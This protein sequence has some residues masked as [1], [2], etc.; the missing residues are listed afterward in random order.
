VKLFLSSIIL[1][2]FLLLVPTDVEAKTFQSEHFSFEYPK[3][4]KAEGQEN[5]FSGFEATVEKGSDAAIKFEFDED[6]DTISGTDEEILDTIETNVGSLYDGATVFESSVD[7]YTINNQSAPYAI[8]QFSKENLFGYEHDYV[9]LM[10]AI[11]L[12]DD[13]VLAQYIGSEDDFDNNL[14]AV[15]K[16][17][18]SVRPVS[19]TATGTENSFTSQANDPQKTKALCDTVTTQ[20]AQDLCEQLL[21]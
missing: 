3:G 7:K 12:G 20:S 14:P 15:E 13:I 4:W 2:S 16:I 10:M 17:L 18:Q 21:N 9:D 5:R 11:H 1:A 19:G 6:S 8:V